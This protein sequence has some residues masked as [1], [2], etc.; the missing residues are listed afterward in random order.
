[1]KAFDH[2]SHIKSD[3]TLPYLRNLPH[4]LSQIGMILIK[5]QFMI[6]LK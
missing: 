3:C 5:L 1:M 4:Y 6:D 2:I